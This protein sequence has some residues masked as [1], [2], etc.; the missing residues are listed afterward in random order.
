MA[1]AQ[2]IINRVRHLINDEAS[3][4]VSG[5]RW[6][7]T[8]MLEWITDGEREIVQLKPEANTVTALFDVVGD[9]PRQRLDPTVAYRLIRV[10]ANGAGT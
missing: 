6:S 3:A 10:E 1:T 5:L 8:E 7:D 4:F 9:L 2:D